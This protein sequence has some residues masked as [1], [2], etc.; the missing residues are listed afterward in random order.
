[1]KN[2]IFTFL[3][4][5]LIFKSF[6]NNIAITNV[7]LT[8]QNV[9]AGVN[10]PANFTMVQ[11]TVSWENSYRLNYG[12]NNWDAAWIFVKYRVAGGA[13]DHARLSNTGHVAP[14]G[15]TIATGLQT[16]STA[17]NS[18]TNP[19]LGAFLYRSAAG[20]GTLTATNVQLRWNYG[21]NAIADNAVIEVQVYGIEM[22]F[23]PQAAF[24]VG[25]AGGS[26]AFTSTTINTS[27]ATTIPTGTGTLGGQAGGYPTGQTAPGVATWPN[28]F[29]GFYCM[30]Y[31][32]SQQQ[33]VDFLN[34]LTASQAAARYSTTTASRCAIVSTSGVYSTTA[35]A[36]AM[37][38]FNWADLAAY[39][40]WSALRPMTE[41]EYEKACRGN[42]PAVNG[43]YAWGTNT[44]TFATGITNSGLLNEGI[45][46]AGANVNAGSNT[47]PFRVGIFGGATTTRVQSGATFYGIMEMTGNVWEL[48]IALNTTE[49]RL[50][51]GNHGNGVLGATGD[52]NETSWP[53]STSASGASV[54]GGAF[55]TG[56]AF[57][58]VS[59]RYVGATV[60]TRLNT[61]GG[62][63]V[64]TTP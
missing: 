31:E 9:T 29:A 37:G 44:L 63:G 7:E 18:T 15:T 54:R 10:N 60:A 34:N 49:G 42:L 30:K 16:P 12:P 1:M 51:A 39:M 13:W 46:N 25:G 4:F 27:V 45:S 8:G 38:N 58:P 61:V 59:F 23:V 17:F 64:R 20:T 35:P 5:G 6:A 22:V 36:V 2:L 53:V 14:T 47:F 55:S 62:R 43:E 21:A 50:F 24:N 57:M 11:F 19:G 56:T 52:H 48:A 3:F 40:D 32:I 33:Y 26:N 41:M 28:G